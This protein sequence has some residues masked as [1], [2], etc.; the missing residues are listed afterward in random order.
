[1]TDVAVVI[2]VSG[3]FD[4]ASSEGF[5]PRISLKEVE[6]QAELRLDTFLETTI[7]RHNEVILPVE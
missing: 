2:A 6:V 7:F 4:S 1:V 5:R 3:D